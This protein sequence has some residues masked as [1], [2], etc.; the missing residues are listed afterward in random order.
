[1]HGSNVRRVHVLDVKIA[2]VRGFQAPDHEFVIGGIV[3]GNNATPTIAKTEHPDTGDCR[4]NVFVP[5]DQ[6]YCLSLDDGSTHSLLGFSIFNHA[7]MPGAQT[8]ALPVIVWNG[9]PERYAIFKTKTVF[10]E[11]PF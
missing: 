7:C 10:D 5:T 4:Y 8:T 9:K 2:V 1:M 6:G 3:D 11:T